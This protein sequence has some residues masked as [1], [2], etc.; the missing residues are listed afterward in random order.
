[1]DALVSSMQMPLISLGLPPL[2][3]TTGRVLLSVIDIVKALH[4]AWA[5][6]HVLVLLELRSFFLIAL[7]IWPVRRTFSLAYVLIEPLKV[8]KL[9]SL[10]DSVPS[11]TRRNAFHFL[12]IACIA[13]VNILILLLEVCIWT[14]R[15]QLGASWDISQ[16][17]CH[18][19]HLKPVSIKNMQSVESLFWS[20]PSQG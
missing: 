11:W 8:C 18:F 9:P 3:P 17:F 14:W 6:V 1:M 16:H 10:W 19:Y 4:Q 15:K 13:S 12:Q 20:S 5:V 7:M 2:A